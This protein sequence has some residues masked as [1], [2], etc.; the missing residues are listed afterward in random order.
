MRKFNSRNLQENCIMG[1]V[2]DYY[3]GP[4]RYRIVIGKPLSSDWS[5]R[6]AEMEIKPI[7]NESGSGDMTELKGVIKD[8]AQLSGI[9]GALIDFGYPLISIQVLDGDSES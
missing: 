9:L 4:H 3:R 2:A 6:L 5:N 8:Q 1:K 7:R